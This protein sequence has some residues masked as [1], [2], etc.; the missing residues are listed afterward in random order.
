MKVYTLRID[1]EAMQRE[2][3]DI[4][5]VMI[6]VPDSMGKAD[7]EKMMVT[8]IPNLTKYY[9]RIHCVK[10]ERLKICVKDEK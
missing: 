1:R 2:I 7:A 9:Y 3:K 10:D 6:R 4:D 5:G 8:S